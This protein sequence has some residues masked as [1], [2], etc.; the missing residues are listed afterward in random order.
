MTTP[1][2]V[3][4]DSSSLTA[5]RYYTQYDPYYYSVDNRPLQD[6]SA[7]ITTI[8]SGGGDSARRGLLLNELAQS[9]VFRSLFSNSGATG[10]ITGLGV[11][12]PS[13]NTIKITPGAWYFKD[14]INTSNTTQVVK[15]ALLLATPQFTVAPP[16]TAGQSINYLVQIQSS[17]LNATTMLTSALPFVDATNTFLP[18]IL[19]NGELLVTLKTGTAATTG[20][21]S[22][23]NADSGCIPLYVVTATYGSTVPTVVFAA[24]CPAYNKI[25]STSAIL[26]PV[27]T[28]AVAVDVGGV[29]V[30]SFADA[31]TTKI[32]VHVPVLTGT[33]NPFAPVKVTVVYSGSV[34]SGNVQAQINYLPLA[35]GGSTTGSPVSL[36]AEVLTAPA[37]ANT[38]SSYTFTGTIPNSAFAGFVNNSWTINVQR[39][40]VGIQRNGAAGA[41]TM[42]GTFYIHDVILSQ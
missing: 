7:N 3:P 40:Y 10:Y 31:A 35:S 22:T 8:S 37:T 28:P 15:Q 14:N 38:I 5:V 16:G 42:A 34:N 27:A 25:S 17:T 9:E 1:N 33:I 2:F 24:S 32:G 20:T 21:Q 12:N 41:D 4:Q 6:L 39:L 11:N 36:T 18:G 26:Y 29:P 13:S 30:P 19:L 23:P